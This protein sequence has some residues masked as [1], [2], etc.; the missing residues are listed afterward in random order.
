MFRKRFW[1]LI[2]SIIAFLSSMF[3]LSGFAETGSDYFT[4]KVVDGYAAIVSASTEL[5]GR[6]EVPSVLG[7]YQVK[8]IAE[9]AFYKCNGISE[10]SIP[11]GIETIGNTA[12]GYCRNLEK[13][14]IADS[15]TEIGRY[16][17]RNCDKMTSIKLSSGLKALSS[18]IFN[19]CRAIVAIE[20]PEEITTFNNYA[21]RN[22][23]S[24]EKINISEN[25]TKIAS[26]TFTGCTALKEINVDENNAKYTS[27]DGILFDKNKTKLEYYPCAHGID[28]D[29]PETVLDISSEA[30][31][32]NKNLV[33]VSIPSQISKIDS[34]MF[35]GCSS[36][37]RIDVAENNAHFVS[38]DG[39]LYDK[40][41]SKLIVYPA[42]QPTEYKLP[43]TLIEIDEN[44]F[45]DSSIINLYVSNTNTLFASDNGVLFNKDKTELVSFPRGRTGEY[46]VP[47]TVERIGE[48]AFIQ[49]NNLTNVMLPVKLKEIAADAFLE[50]GLLSITI[51]E[52]VITIGDSAFG[53]CHS[54]TEV[55]FK[56]ALTSIESGAFNNCTQLRSVSLLAG[57]V[58]IKESTFYNCSSLKYIIIPNSIKSIEYGA[59]GNIFTELEI[60]YSG[61][62][63]EWN[64]ITIEEDNDVLSGATVHYGSSLL[65]KTF[66]C[67]ETAEVT[68]KCV[69]YKIIPLNAPVNTTVTLGIYRGN[70][71]VDVK[72]VSYDGR[73]LELDTNEKDC[74]AKVF[75]WDGQSGSPCCGNVSIDSE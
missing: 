55:T 30:F 11:S 14:V 27:I 18:D 71:L 9:R 32:G 37:S 42:T 2:V 13:V 59:F 4:Y 64:Q 72:C 52:N 48:H 51:P 47:D 12:F 6:V 24:L 17:F 43:D 40:E 46:A 57:T 16:A 39:V 69:V 22:C 68:D 31:R 21:F 74:T 63:E 73:P 50:C 44:A 5:S 26:G 61:T 10:I 19:N 36:L 35:L 65:P 67:A 33:R 70:R 7:G 29:I 28:Y 60:Y 49:C 3:P 34:I 53:D 58:A 54:M 23:T 56:G 1:I 15:V 38:V 41:K 45:R 25:V 62:E 8:E 20:I 75:L 66:V